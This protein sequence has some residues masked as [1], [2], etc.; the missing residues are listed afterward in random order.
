MEEKNNPFSQASLQNLHI[1][2]YNIFTLIY[3][4]LFITQGDF[5]N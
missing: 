5:L 2:I 3:W 1:S 4:K